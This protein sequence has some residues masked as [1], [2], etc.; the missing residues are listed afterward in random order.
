MKY[1][2]RALFI[3][4]SLVGLIITVG[5]LFPKYI[6]TYLLPERFILI[7]TNW[8][9]IIGFIFTSVG[10]LLL[11]QKK[12]HLHEISCDRYSILEIFLILTLLFSTVFTIGWLYGQ[13]DHMQVVSTENFEKMKEQ[14]IM[15]D[16]ME[17]EN[18]FYS[19]KVIIRDDD[20]GN[21]SYIESVSWLS[22]L[23]VGKDVK[24]TYALIPAELVS[25]PETVIYLNALDR[26]YF[27]F[28][29]HGYE[30]IK[31]K[32]LPYNEQYYQIEKATKIIEMKL[33][34]KP[35]TFV[36]PYGSGDINTTKV[37]KLL[38]YHSITDALGYPSYIMDF[39]SDFE[40]ENGY[41]P[42][43]HHKFE[44]FKNSY[45]RFC[46]SSDEYY[47]IYLH[48]WTFLNEHLNLDEEKTRE[49][50]KA[51]DYMKTDDVQFITIEEA[52]KW[53]IDEPNIRTF[54][55]DKYN[56]SVDLTECQYNHTLKFHS[57]LD[58]NESIIVTDKN[59]DDKMY[60]NKSMFEFDGI[61]G[62]WYVISI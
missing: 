31:F 27:E 36:P 37:C 62:H 58:L 57:P 20:V 19:K 33:N 35:F 30:H 10:L 50:E 1:L 2:K 18:P 15:Q 28:A 47:I 48:D 45:D 23:C 60:F 61:K 43:S 34:F 24:A 6:E 13:Y 3:S 4:I 29:V 25:N 17:N 52:Y 7:D 11:T 49:F 53:R 39:T 42:V 51:I 8:I 38:G 41:N 32:D 9:I 22:D 26:T 54:K 46:N 12:R 59:T 16:Y 56:Y 40:W 14:L 21:F 55:I 44:D 5:G